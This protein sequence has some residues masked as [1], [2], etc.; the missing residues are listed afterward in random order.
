VDELLISIVS[1]PYLAN[2]N[3]RLE[4]WILR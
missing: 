1:L 4:K 3:F 2:M